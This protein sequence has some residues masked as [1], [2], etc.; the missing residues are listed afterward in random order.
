MAPKKST[1]VIAVFRASPSRPLIQP[2]ACKME[3]DFRNLNKAELVLGYP[4]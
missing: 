1:F 4:K 3:T 2:F